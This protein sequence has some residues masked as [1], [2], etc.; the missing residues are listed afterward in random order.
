MIDTRRFP[1]GTYLLRLTADGQE[2]Q[3]REVV[4]LH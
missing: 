3:T 2:V 4:I 1:S